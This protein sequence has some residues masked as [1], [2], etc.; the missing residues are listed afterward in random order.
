MGIVVTTEQ[1][2]P[3]RRRPGWGLW[4][5]WVLAA[6]GSHLA[7]LLVAWV[8]TEGVSNQGTPGR[9]AIGMV[10]CFPLLFLS[11]ITVATS[12]WLVLRYYHRELATSWAIITLVGELVATFVAVFLATYLNWTLNARANPMLL[13][14]GIVVIMTLFRLIAGGAQWLVLIPH[15]ARAHRW[16][17]WNALAGVI[18]GVVVVSA[19]LLDLFGFGLH[20]GLL[21]FRVVVAMITGVAL[22]RL[23][24]QPLLPQ[25]YHVNI[26]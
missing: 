13:Y 14:A 3:T 23:L 2:Q 7:F 5:W 22:A 26:T 18:G 20:I 11:A 15:F 19:L 16:V 10:I 6:A 8:S 17:A 25:A 4:L 1:G 12:Q 21:T 9:Y 24:Q